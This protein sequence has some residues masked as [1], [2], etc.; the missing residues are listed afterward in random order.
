[1]SS[2]SPP[3]NILIRNFRIGFGVHSRI[4]KK[5]LIPIGIKCFLWFCV[6]FRVYCALSIVSGAYQIRRVTSKVCQKDI[7]LNFPS[8]VYFHVMSKFFE[9]NLPDSFLVSFQE[10][11][12]CDGSTLM[13]LSRIGRAIWSWSNRSIIEP[14]I[15][16]GNVTQNMKFCWVWTYSP[17]F[18]F[19]LTREI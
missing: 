2:T 4:L 9:I 10:F 16:F 18:T 14:M 8:S 7:L 15:S 19:L 5:V 3:R 13:Q 12:L 1:M 6:L 11:M 17:V